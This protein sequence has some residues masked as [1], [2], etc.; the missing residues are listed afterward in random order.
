MQN[1]LIKRFGEFKYFTQVTTLQYAR[2]NNGTSFYG[3]SNLEYLDLTNITYIY[4]GTSTGN[5]GSPLRDTKLVEL[6]LPNI[7]RLNQYAFH[8]GSSSNAIHRRINIG[9]SFTTISS[10]YVFTYLYGASIKLLTIIPA[11]GST[12]NASGRGSA[13]IYVPDNSVDTYKAA[14]AWA[15]WKNYIK[16]LSECPW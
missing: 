13:Y 8:N 3:C 11:T 6:N 16:P 12:L 10:A 9:E 14:A 4:G 1:T 15:N 2:D 7:V 5:V